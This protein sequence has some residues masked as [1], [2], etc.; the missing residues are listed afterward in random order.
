MYFLDWK[1]VKWKLNTND[2]YSQIS[3][4]CIFITPKYLLSCKT[5]MFI[6]IC[7][8]EKLPPNKSKVVRVFLAFLFCGLEYV[9]WNTFAWTIR[10]TMLIFSGRLFLKMMFCLLVSYETYL[11]I[12]LCNIFAY[13]KCCYINR[14]NI[15]EIDSKYSYS[16]GN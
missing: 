7:Q 8:W 15:I 2:E 5:K 14:L 3:S 13:P 9:T 4:M 12:I 16:L 11:Q 10:I 6:I 1:T